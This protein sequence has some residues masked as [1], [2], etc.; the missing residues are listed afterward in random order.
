MPG[1]DAVYGNVDDGAAVMAGVPGGTF[2]LH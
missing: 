2:G 1:V